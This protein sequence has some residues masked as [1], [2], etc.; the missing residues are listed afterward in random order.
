MGEEAEVEEAPEVEEQFAVGTLR[1]F[2]ILG[3]VAE[4]SRVHEDVDSVLVLLST[5]SIVRQPTKSNA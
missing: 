4:V 1:Y 3:D 5:V 2:S